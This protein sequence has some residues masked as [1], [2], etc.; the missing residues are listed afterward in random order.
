MNSFKKSKETEIPSMQVVVEEYEHKTGAKHYHFKPTAKVTD[1][2]VFMVALNTW[3]QDDTGVAHI[4][5]HTALC[6]SKK[7][8]VKDPFF[9]MI[10]RSMQTFMNAITANDWTAYPFATQNKKDY[11]NLTEVYLDAVFFANLKEESFQQ[12]G[13]R[14]DFKTPGDVTSDLVYKGVVYNEMKGAMSQS[15]RQ[16]VE[17]ISKHLLSGSTYEKN[18]GGAVASIPELT[19]QKLKEFYEVFYHPSNALFFTYGT[20]PAEEQQ[21]R[22]E[23][24]ALGQFSKINVKESLGLLGSGSLLTRSVPKQ[25]LPKIV[26]SS[27]STS[28]KIVKKGANEVLMVWAMNDEKDKKSALSLELLSR[29]L[30]GDG[31]SK[32]S[33]FS[34]SFGATHSGLESSFNGFDDGASKGIWRW[35]L[36]QVEDRHVEKAVEAMEKEWREWATHPVSVQRLS[37]ELNRMEVEFKEYGSGWPHGLSL[38]MDGLQ[39]AISGGD[40]KDMID[41]LPTI[42]A[43]KKDIQK[44][45]FTSELLHTWFVENTHRLTYVSRADSKQLKMESDLEAKKLALIKERMS[46]E[47]KAKIVRINKDLGQEEKTSRSNG[48]P[49][50]SI[51][52]VPRVGVLREKSQ[53]VQAPYGSWTEV[54]SPT[55]GIQYAGVLMRATPMSNDDLKW[56]G[57]YQSL[58]LDMPVGKRTYQETQEWWS[59]EVAGI[60]FGLDFGLDANAKVFLTASWDATSKGEDAS[61]V[62]SLFKF[63]SD[64][65]RFDDFETLK[66]NIREIHQSQLDELSAH[67]AQYAGI[68]SAACFSLLSRLEG[69]I[70]GFD[71]L[72]HWDAVLRLSKSKN[73]LRVIA[74]KMEHIHRQVGEWSKCAY[75]IGAEGVNRSVSLEFEKCIKSV[76]IKDAEA[77][78]WE[79][80]CKTQEV[81]ENKMWTTED[82]VSA[83][84]LTVKGP[85]LAN[86]KEFAQML[87]LCAMINTQFLHKE[88]REKGG[89]YGTGCQSINGVVRFQSSRDPR[90]SDT[91]EDFRRAMVWAKSI[92]KSE[93]EIGEA[94]LGVIKRMDLPQLPYEKAVSEIFVNV[95]K[96][97]SYLMQSLRE[98]VLDVDANG[99]KQVAE[100]YFKDGVG[101]SC[102]SFCNASHRDALVA[103]GFE[104]IED[105]V[106][107]QRE[108]AQ[109]KSGCRI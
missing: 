37:D 24:L 47:E 2:N 3:P 7:F 20:I 89:A 39:C 42:E 57:V 22:W 25:S 97:E 34:K 14:Y 92:K 68:E 27:H 107:H 77:I 73:G 46:N 105:R 44:P 19:H 63:W 66:R 55:R 80:L 17:G 86:T 67:G 6:G 23:K 103:Q 95:N 40:A 58:V 18:S 90:A 87:V 51:Q 16:V 31:A 56:L 108:S 65:L 102:V 30:M 29:V 53:W 96:K 83:N 8:D 50:L 36:T 101:Q 93:E 60:E 64:G 52:D 4:L 12:E 75:A 32:V 26:N 45:D 28:Q 84:V 104:S 59:K 11:E 9:S 41:V 85:D 38:L 100:K 106:S 79:G 91:F 81:P 61:K 48:L 69:Q 74:E 99:L 5:E 72:K 21:L 88:V 43:L 13:W 76:P 15:S 78:E 109:E 10:N 33:E 94:V 71:A 54:I 98:H 82:A 1:E 49:S 62:P 70:E 35:G